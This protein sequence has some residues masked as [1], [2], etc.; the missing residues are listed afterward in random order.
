MVELL[1]LLTPTSPMVRTTCAVVVVGQIERTI[2]AVDIV[3]SH[4]V[5]EEWPWSI[6]RRGV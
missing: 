6:D 1:V 3:A 4:A 5:I 2:A